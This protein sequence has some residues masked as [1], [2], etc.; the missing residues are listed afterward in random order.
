MY[1]IINGQTCDMN[2]LSRNYILDLQI[3]NTRYSRE[4]EVFRHNTVGSEHMPTSL[5][6]H[7]NYTIER[8]LL[9]K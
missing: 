5:V 3:I 6:Y 4:H 8:V 2:Q 7:T 1:A 9:N